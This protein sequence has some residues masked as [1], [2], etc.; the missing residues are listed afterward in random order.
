M[1]S[2][3]RELTAVDT[4]VR[5]PVG[6]SLASPKS[7]SFGQ[8]SSSNSTFDDLKSRYITFSFRESK[9]YQFTGEKSNIVQHSKSLNK[10]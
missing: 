9:M 7:E 8:N 1:N 2:I 4:C 10:H 6:P 5:S 3:S